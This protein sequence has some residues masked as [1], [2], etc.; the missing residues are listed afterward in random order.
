[1]AWLIRKS[2]GVYFVAW[3]ETT[4]RPKYQ[5]AG[6]N[7]RLALRLKT[8][9]EARLLE[10]SVGSGVV[11]KKTTV[12]EFAGVVKTATGRWDVMNPGPGSWLALRKVRPK[13]ADRERRLLRVHILPEFGDT[14]LSSIRVERA[15]QFFK[16]LEDAVSPYTA[17]RAKAVMGK[18]FADAVRRDYLRENI[19]ERT[20]PIHLPT[21]PREV[22][23][24]ALCELLRALPAEWRAFAYFAIR[25]GLRWGEIAALEWPDIDFEA[26]KIRVRRQVP[27]NTTTVASL[28]TKSSRRDVDL[29]PDVKQILLDQPQRGRLVFPAMRGGHISHRWFCR[30]VWGPA[31]KKAGLNLRF[32]GLRHAFGSLLLLWSEDMDIP[33]VSRQ[34]GHS[35]N[36]VTLN[37]YTHEVTERRRFDKAATIQ[38]LRDAMGTAEGGMAYQWLTTGEL[39]LEKVV[40]TMGFEPT[41]SAMRVRRSPN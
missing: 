31:V 15:D 29:A 2:N 35:S 30:S 21:E 23:V 13:T 4:R 27:A 39:N 12:A 20:D 28:K 19:I 36:T 14:L 38:R 17:H 10:G 26:S 40:E 37:V 7:K 41:T 16:R 34:M 11:P 9:I 1:M 25:T 22:S 3:R 5:K 8:T 33:Y 24:E 18:M 6:R 32:H